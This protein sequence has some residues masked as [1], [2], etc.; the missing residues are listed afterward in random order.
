MRVPALVVIGLLAKHAFGDCSFVATS[1]QATN[2]EPCK[3][4]IGLPAGTNPTVSLHTAGALL[5]GGP[6]G[7][8]GAHRVIIGASSGDYGMIGFNT[9]PTPQGPTVYEP[10]TGADYA[11]MIR[12]YAGGVQFRTTAQMPTAGQPISFVEA[13]MIHRDGKVGIGLGGAT[14][15]ATLDVAGSIRASGS[16]TGATVM[17]AIFQDL[18]EW[19]PAAND[20][21][22][23]TVVVLSTARN[24]EV[25]ASTKSYDT[26]V[27]GVV[28]AQ[29][30]VLLGV[31]GESK[32]MI[33]TTGRV[34]VLVDATK[35]PIEIGDLL[36][37]SESAGRAMKSA[38]VSIGGI[39]VHR[40]GTIVGKALEPLRGGSGEILVLLS[41][42]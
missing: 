42:Q 3:V 4:G 15:Q 41:L 39:E 17:G 9:M 19:V 5:V 2:P 21:A 13:M 33:A 1:T 34:R 40:P 22:P 24:N 7:S 14:P 28:S 8:Y 16:I 11:S 35:A 38:P 30:G 20:L 18:A 10:A 29:P 12:F 23:G 36:V 37:T 6:G 26:R 31:S 32:E 25:T 27:A